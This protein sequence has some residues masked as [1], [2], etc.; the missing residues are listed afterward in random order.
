[1][2]ALGAVLLVAG[3]LLIVSGVNVNND[4][5]AQM[6]SLFNNGTSNPGSSCIAI[7][8]F[9]AAVGLL[10]LIIG[11]VQYYQ[12]NGSRQNM[13]ASNEMPPVG[14]CWNCGGRITDKSEYCSHCGTKIYKQQ[15]KFCR[16]CGKSIAASSAFCP[17]CGNKI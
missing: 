1:M 4:M 16:C 6:E 7:G 2:I 8:V 15:N 10:L 17:Y 12:R 5:E 14:K 11:I 3:L 13:N 9:I